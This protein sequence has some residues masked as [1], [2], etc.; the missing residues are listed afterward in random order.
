MNTDALIEALARDTRPLSA[1]SIE[2]RLGVGIAAGGAAAL[3]LLLAFLGTRPD[4][5]A[6]AAKPMFWGKAAYP[7]ALGAIGLVLAAQLARPDIGRLRWIWLLP[8]PFMPLM[9]L[10]GAELIRASPAA[11][12]E[13]LFD[14]AWKCLPLIAMLAAPVFAGLVWSFR[15]LAPTQL[16]AAG[17]ALGLTAG[18]VGAAVYCLYCQQ[19]SPAYLLTRYTAAIALVSAAGALLGPR[20]LRW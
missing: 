12:A 3:L 17:A 15:R 8:L 20:L 18:G 19:I 7:L 6:A 2:R 11:R 14:P 1:R 13:I 16:R 10:A 4:L 9:A 5:Q